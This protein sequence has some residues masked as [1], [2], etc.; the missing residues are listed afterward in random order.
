MK[1]IYE[2]T[3]YPPYEVLK[4]KFISFE[5]INKLKYVEEM[6][7]IFYNSL[8]YENTLEMVV[9]KFETPFDFYFERCVKFLTFLDRS[10]LAY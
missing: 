3:S 10:L 8:R 4:N 6:V 7:D 2:Y 1:K 9:E 5:E